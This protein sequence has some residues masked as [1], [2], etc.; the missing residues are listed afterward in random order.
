MIK[1]NT[2]VSAAVAVSTFEMIGA[3]IEKPYEPIPDLVLKVRKHEPV[4]ALV[5]RGEAGR[6][7]EAMIAK[8]GL[9]LPNDPEERAKLLL[10]YPKVMAAGQSAFVIAMAKEA[11]V[12]WAGVEGAEPKSLAPLSPENIEKVMQIQPIFDWFDR[13]YVQPALSLDQE[14]NGSSPSQN[15]TTSPGAMIT[16]VDAE[17][18]ALSAQTS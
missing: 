11:I 10:E 4:M 15:T 17:N 8:L 12:E 3:E 1:I 9:T 6:A 5:A 13:D 16:A 14:K 2:A 7:R 18:L